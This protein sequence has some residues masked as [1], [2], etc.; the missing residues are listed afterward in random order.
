MLAEIKFLDTDSLPLS[1][2]ILHR[3]VGDRDICPFVKP[4]SYYQLAFGPLDSAEEIEKAIDYAV[5]LAES[6]LSRRRGTS[7]QFLINSET[8]IEWC[9]V[10]LESLRFFAHQQ[11]AELV[12]RGVIKSFVI[13]RESQWDYV[14]E[15]EP[16]DMKYVEHFSAGYTSV[17]HHVSVRIIE[18]SLKHDECHEKEYAQP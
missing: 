1:E 9:Y 6:L 7:Y 18:P 10:P 2:E 11:L 8:S 3:L 12:R 4:N 17:D 14:A 5:T 16:V 15:V 13:K